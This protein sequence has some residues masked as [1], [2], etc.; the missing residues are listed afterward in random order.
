MKL[1]EAKNEAKKYLEKSEL[2]YQT[3]RISWSGRH[4]LAIFS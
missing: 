3:Q 1:R 2:C 4:F